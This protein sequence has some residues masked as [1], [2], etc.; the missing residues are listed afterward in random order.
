[1]EHYE[2]R[3]IATLAIPADRRYTTLSHRWSSQSFLKLTRNNFQRLSRGFL[4]SDLPQTFRDAVSATYHLGFHYLW[5]DSLC[6][7]QDDFDDWARQSAQ[8]H[9]IYASA[10]CNLAASWAEDCLK[11]MFSHRP[12]SS[13]L[14]D[15]I[16]LRARMR[17]KKMRLVDESIWHRYIEDSPLRK[18]GWIFQ[19]RFLSPRIMHFCEDQIL[20]ECR[21]L[22]ASE[23][24]HLGFWPSSL[25]PPAEQTDVPVVSS[26]YYPPGLELSLTQ[27]SSFEKWGEI[28][29]TYSPTSLTKNTDRLVAFSGVAG[30]FAASRGCEASAYVAGMWRDTLELSMF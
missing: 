5:I 3:L 19:E 14:A 24:C 21:E 23:N 29:K 13:K 6:I 26:L 1:M 17:Y 15:T 8:M 11:P 22:H 18:R 30:A 7:I 9:Q 25:L 16:E 20:W 12:D 27:L 28:V 10:V 4:S 2:L